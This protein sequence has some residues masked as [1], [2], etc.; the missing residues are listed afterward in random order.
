MP[1][2]RSASRAMASASSARWRGGSCTLAQ[3]KARC[4]GLGAGLRLVVELRLG[5]RLGLGTGFGLEPE[6]QG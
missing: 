2:A 5:L 6:C 4:G 3:P 1:A